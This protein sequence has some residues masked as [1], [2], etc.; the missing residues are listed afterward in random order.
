MNNWSGT[1]K[2]KLYKNTRTP[3]GW[4]GWA[5]IADYNTS[6]DAVS[7]GGGSYV[8]FAARDGY[9]D[10]ATRPAIG[11]VSITFNRLV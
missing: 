2:A 7:I 3:G 9:I 4:S 11:G 1:G 8:Y 10:W 5:Q 6:S